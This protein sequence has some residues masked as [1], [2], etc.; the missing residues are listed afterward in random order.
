MLLEY[1]EDQTK[2]SLVCNSSLSFCPIVSFRVEMVAEVLDVNREHNKFEVMEQ[3]IHH[4]EDQVVLRETQ[5]S[6]GQE[7]T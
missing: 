7:H 4:L 1:A 3:T 2:V 5:P 6:M